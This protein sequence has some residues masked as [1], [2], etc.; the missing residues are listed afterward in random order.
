[1]LLS[2]EV[3]FCVVWAL[4]ELSEIWTGEDSLCWHWTFCLGCVLMKSYSWSF[5][6]DIWSLSQESIESNPILDV[7]LVRNDC[8][9]YVFMFCPV[10]RICRSEEHWHFIYYIYQNL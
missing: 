1:M 3:Y 2:A 9:T 10:V 6:L 5:I 4:P 7:C 8:L